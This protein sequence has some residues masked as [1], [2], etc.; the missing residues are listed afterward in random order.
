M[1]LKT[2]MVAAC[3]LAAAVSVAHA[4]PRVVNITGATLLENYV[5]AP[6]ST[7]DYIDV[8]GDGVAGVFGSGSIDQLA[9]AITNPAAP[10]ASA[11][12][13][14]MYRVSGS[15]Q[16][17]IELTTFGGPGFVTTDDTDVNGILGAR[18]PAVNGFATTAY[19]NRTKY[20]DVGV[21]TGFYNQGNPGGAPF[22][23]DVTTLAA[24]YAPPPSGSSG[25][26]RIDVAPMDVSPA[27]ATLKSGGSAAWNRTPTIAGY[28][29]NARVSTNRQ[30]TL[31]GFGNLTN[32]LPGLNGRNLFDP[33]NPGAANGNTIFST[34]LSFAPIATVTNPGTG[35]TRLKISEMQHLFVTGRAASG[36][37]LMVCTR[38]YGSGTRNAH[39][40]CLGI[41]PSWAV[42]DNVGGVSTQT[43][44]N[45]LGSQFTPTNK[46]ASGGIEA[47]L[48]NARLGVGYSGAE[49]G[50]TGGSPAS[51]LLAGALEIVDTM[52]DVYGGTQY[53]RPTAANVVHNGPNGWVIGGPSVLATI[54]D[55]LSEPVSAGGEG[56][57]RPR[58]ANPYA[59]QYINNIRRSIAAFV[60]VPADPANLGM[61]GEYAATQFVL[62]NAQDFV[63]DQTIPTLMVANGG[64][65]ASLQAYTVANSVYNNALYAQSN[66]FTGLVPA[67]TNGTTYS[68]GVAGGTNYVAQDGSAVAYGSPLT[69]R[70][71][72]AGDFNGDGLRNVNDAAEMMRAI[73][74]RLGGPAWSAPAG[75]GPLAGAPGTDAVIEI[76]GD[77]DGDGSFTASDVRYWAD[78]LAVQ[79]TGPRAGKLDRKAGFTAVD[80]AWQTLTGNANFFATTKAHGAYA[81][82]DSRA[83]V[84]G[85]G[86]VNP[87][88][89]PVGADG[90]IDARDIDYIYRQ[91]KQNASVTDGEANWDNL[92]EA[93]T[94]DLSCDLTG[95]LRVN[96]DDIT[97]I[98]AI[99]GTG[100]GDVNLDGVVDATDCTI[101]TSNLGA[102]NVGWAGGDVDG[103]GVVT[104]AD[105]ALICP[106]T[107]CDTDFTCD[108]NADQD[109]VTALVNAIASADYSGICLD[110]DFNLDGNVDQDDISAL[111]NRLA[112][113]GCP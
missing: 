53:V 106:P 96:Q 79:V 60:S 32:S 7:N 33:A 62:P 42:G 14:V 40:N 24:T 17:F 74:Q 108:G 77:F 11:Y 44:N 3:G 76:L 63:H 104:A 94:T 34:S 46:N 6:A 59:A 48:R 27:W 56:L 52:N 72:I 112:G 45:N 83:D 113:G 98:L 16:G 91:F 4:Q 29:A 109:D 12:W 81:A 19:L 10:P 75:S 85:S 49:R 26:I 58:M 51:W 105:L 35:I 65:S 88:W 5:R 97:D 93:S 1:E 37:N 21:A 23:S 66:G 69:L 110:P 82:G 47:S 15:V 8:D 86:G 36:E 64:Y 57:T 50:V 68:D 73:R 13:A 20:I 61:P 31:T 2:A 101:A 107:D 70:N 99:L 78:G 92:T 84:I 100:M 89:A 22:R 30:G 55:P 71:K 67:R 103:D 38:E 43:V 87:G 28:G 39:A 41:D 102:V 95:D 111:V 54:G 80:N 18:P 9:P 90:I 25:G